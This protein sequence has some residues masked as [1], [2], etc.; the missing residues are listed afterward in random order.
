VHKPVDNF[1]IGKGINGFG[2]CSFFDHF[3]CEV[4]PLV[5]AGRREVLASANLFHCTGSRRRL[6][7]PFHI[8]RERLTRRGCDPTLSRCS[9]ADKSSAASSAGCPMPRPLTFAE[10]PTTGIPRTSSRPHKPACSSG[11]HQRRREARVQGKLTPSHGRSRTRMI[12]GIGTWRWPSSAGAVST[13]SDI[14][15]QLP[16]ELQLPFQALR[17]PP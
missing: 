6:R 8:R 11:G 17:E 15:L 10:H 14:S 13:R 4:A 1:R 2:R 9:A 3:R 12:V 5:K 7:A 16:R